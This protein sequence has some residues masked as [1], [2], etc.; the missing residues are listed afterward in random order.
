VGLPLTLHGGSGTDNE[1]FRKTIQ[2]GITMIHINTE[3][4]VAWRKGLEEALAKDAE[5]VA[6]Y[7]VL[8]G[9]VS[10]V[11]AVMIERLKLFNGID[12]AA[13]AQKSGL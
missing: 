4:R 13:R 11:K 12:D 5:S 7:K 8:P 6:P 10:R 1:D 9:V 2:A 3:L